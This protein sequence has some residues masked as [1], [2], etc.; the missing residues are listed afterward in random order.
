[1]PDTFD[2]MA[3]MDFSRARLNEFFS[4]MAGFLD[5]ERNRLLALDEVRS[6]LK[7]RGEEYR[8]MMAVPVNR[9]V[10]SE[11][12]YRDFAR[13]FLPRHGHM[14][15]RWVRV[16]SAHYHDVILP[17][18]RLYE[19]G[20]V[21]FVRDGNHRV[22]VA[23]MQ[24]VLEI[25]AEVT[26]LSSTVHI[27]PDMDMDDLRAALVAYEKKEFY[28]QTLFGQVTDDPDLTLTTAGAYDQIVEHI[29]VHKY[30]LN[31]GSAAEIDFVMA[32][33]SWYR[34]VYRPI[35]D[36][37]RSGRL[38]ARF[39]G[40]TA[41][42]LYLYIV[43]HWDELKKRYGISFPAELA[44]QDF[45][46]RYGAGPL[47]VLAMTARKVLSGLGRLVPGLRIRGAL[48][49]S[50]RQT[51]P[52]YLGA[53]VS[54]DPARDSSPDGGPGYRGASGSPDPARDSGPDGGLDSKP[55]I[56]T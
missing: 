54:P 49:G 44:A 37:I 48:S 1:M 29:L 47:A 11:G 36:I 33:D 45:A 34:T 26:S 19:L 52:G 14:R 16:D 3:E 24:G 55:D 32:L 46:S 50:Q 5:P 23:R 20:G 8:G 4:R 2:T 28:A 35:V 27:E 18:I 12:R 39:P 15:Q 22:S 56:G 38:C 17:P 6:V 53:S 13:G 43:K 25:D 7:I 51:G 42:D 40:R 30:Y 10:G 41:S 9:I 21:Y 31:E